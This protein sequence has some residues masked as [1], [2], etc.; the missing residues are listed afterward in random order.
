MNMRKKFYAGSLE[1]LIGDIH[2]A[3]THN[4]KSFQL[5]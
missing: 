1:E 5:S 4:A 3:K 2:N